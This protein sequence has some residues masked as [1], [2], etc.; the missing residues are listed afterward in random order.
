M[1]RNTF[2]T[3]VIGAIALTSIGAFSLSL[4]H[5]LTN[6]VTHSGGN[7]AMQINQPTPSEEAQQWETQKQRLRAAGIHLT[8]EQ[9]AII[10]QAQRQMAIEVRQNF[11]SNPLPLLGQLIA[12]ATLPQA[13][14]EAL[15][16]MTGL[17]QKLAVPILAYRDTVLNTLTP[18]QRSLW[19]ERI[20]NA[21][22]TQA[23]S[24]HVPLEVYPSTPE[25]KAKE[26]QKTRQLFQDAGM[27]LN[28]EQEAQLQQANDRLQAALEQDFT[29]NPVGTVARF[30]ALTL[31]PQ[32]VLDRVGG[33]LLGIAVLTHVETVNQILTAEQR[34]IWERSFS[35]GR[36]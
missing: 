31:L 12:A 20:W 3:V 16:K 35:Q 13:Q 19:E 11:G 30:F 2:L 15:L 14:G 25:E 24:D 29:A 34:Q 10:R 5:S 33:T 28:P 1:K 27:P 18:E 9:E 36:Y 6:Q 7:M 26:W 17:D 22:N 32:P 21:E 8:P 4:A 23:E